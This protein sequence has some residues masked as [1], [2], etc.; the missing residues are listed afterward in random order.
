M[1]EETKTKQNKKKHAHIQQEQYR[2]TEGTRH[3]H[4]SER[5]RTH[6][7]RG[8]DVSNEAIPPADR[9][10]LVKVPRVRG[11][12]VGKGRPRD[13]RVGRDA[14]VHGR[15]LDVHVAKYRPVLRTKREGCIVRSGCTKK[16]YHGTR[17]RA[18]PFRAVV[19]FCFVWFVSGCLLRCLLTS[20]FNMQRSLSRTP[21]ACW[22]KSGG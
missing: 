11:H 3:A 13:A 15:P 9:V 12:L 7:V 18:R 8:S 17:W 19:I 16:V 4:T 5:A 6:L 14:V 10:R 1:A 22:C 20:A 2:T 21:V